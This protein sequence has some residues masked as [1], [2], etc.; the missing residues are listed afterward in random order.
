[1]EEPF[2]EE[3]SRLIS[4]QDAEAILRRDLPPSQ[5]NSTSDDYTDMTW[6]APTARF[7]VARPALKAPG[8]DGLSGLGDERAGRY[9]GHD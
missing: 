1:M 9:S 5:L 2:I 6:H 8:R 7:Y 3:L 4:P